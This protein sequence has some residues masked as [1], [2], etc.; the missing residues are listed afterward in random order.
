[1]SLWN[2]VNGPPLPATRRP[3]LP[4]RRHLVRQLGVA[5]YRAA[6]AGLAIALME[7]L[8]GLAQ[9]PLARVP[10]VTSIVLVMALPASEPAQARAIIGGHLVS[11]LAGWCVLAFAGQ[12]D[13]AS[14]VAVGVATLAMI[15]LRALHPPA[16]IDAFLMTS[17]ALPASWIV[18]PV[19]IGAL[20][21]TAFAALWSAG[22]RR[23]GQVFRERLAVH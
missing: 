16:G 21:L 10:F 3:R 18:S 11:C 19:L 7:A 5:A 2:S 20:L 8:A 6:G 15:A 17:Q 1:M 13:G 22:E 9:E 12:S 23:L 14:A 4:A